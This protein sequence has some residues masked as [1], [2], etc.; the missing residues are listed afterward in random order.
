MFTYLIK[1]LILVIWTTIIIVM[2]NTNNMDNIFAIDKLLYKTSQH[3]NLLPSPL[4]LTLQNVLSKSDKNLF[5]GVSEGTEGCTLPQLDP[6][7]P[8][9]LHLVNET[10]TVDCVSKQKSLLFIFRTKGLNIV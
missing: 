10:P 6:W 1:Y 2:V 9:I 3:K 7:D 5:P 4:W 8:S